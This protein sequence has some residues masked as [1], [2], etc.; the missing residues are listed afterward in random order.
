VSHLGSLPGFQGRATKCLPSPCATS[1]GHA[2]E[3]GCDTHA[4]PRS[5]DTSRIA[6]A[7]LMA[8]VG[9]EFGRGGHGTHE[10]LISR[11][12]LEDVPLAGLSF[13]FE[14]VENQVMKAEFTPIIIE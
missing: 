3:G 7:K 9:E 8:R 10:S 1:G 5:H 4:K 12:M 2:A 11:T 6:W 13:L 14:N